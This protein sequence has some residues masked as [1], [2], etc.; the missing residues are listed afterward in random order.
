[1]A[2]RPTVF[3]DFATD[4]LNNGLYG[5]PNVQEPPL[6]KKESGWDWGEPPPREWMN[7]IHRI[8]NNWIKYNDERNNEVDKYF[9]SQQ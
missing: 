7:W 5:A 2:T 1:M 6:S 8:S 4:D 9:T 3:P